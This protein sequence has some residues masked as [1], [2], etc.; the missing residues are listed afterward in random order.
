MKKY[1]EKKE[2][3]RKTPRRPHKDT[4]EVAQKNGTPESIAHLESKI[5]RA[6]ERDKTLTTPSPGHIK[7]NELKAIRLSAH[8]NRNIERKTAQERPRS[9]GLTGQVSTM[10]VSRPA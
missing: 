4:A 5:V 8:K 1:G 2:Q 10:A 3:T 9:E 7:D 6:R